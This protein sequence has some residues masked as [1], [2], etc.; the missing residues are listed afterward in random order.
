MS[1]SI[2]LLTTGP[3]IKAL[4]LRG[5]TSSGYN[6]YD[7][8]DNN[9]DK[10]WKT[11]SS[12]A[13]DALDVD[14]GEAKAVSAMAMF[15]NDY[16]TDHTSSVNGWSHRCYYDDDD[17][18]SYT[19]IYN[20]ESLANQLTIPIFYKTFDSTTHRYFKFQIVADAGP[21][22]IAL[23]IGCVWFCRAWT[24]TANEWP[25]NDEDI[26]GNRTDYSMGGR[27]YRTAYR[28]Q[29]IVRK[30][31]TFSFV[32]DTNFGYLRSAYADCR[33][34][35]LPLIL[36]EDDT[37]ST[38]RLCYFADEPFGYAK[39]GAGLY[40]PTVTFEEVPYIPDGETY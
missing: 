21:G 5:M 3:M 24:I 30:P 4:H 38:A 2:K 7:L 29:A 34:S 37:A 16:K 22:Q 19:G 26:Y 8:L 9:P 1:T 18:G 12:P 20:A 33:G 32:D 40:M 28:S 36:I 13:T 11:P 27:P 10:Y 17:A 15:I 23:Y 6:N 35:R 14:L 25:E 39:N 31:R